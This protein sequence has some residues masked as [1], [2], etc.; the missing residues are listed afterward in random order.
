MKTQKTKIKAIYK[1]VGFDPVQVTVEND[2]HALQVMVGG[3]IEELPWPA[4]LKTVMLVDDEGKIMKRPVNFPYRNTE[5]HGSA[6]WVGKTSDDF[7]DCPYNL[8][9][10]RKRWPFLFEEV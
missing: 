5:I 4:G 6:L 1:R 8:E 7:T 10:F 3:Y 9:D 2:L